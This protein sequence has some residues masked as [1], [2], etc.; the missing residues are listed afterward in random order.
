MCG[1]S[2]HYSYHQFHHYP[3]LQLQCCLGFGYHDHSDIFSRNYTYMDMRLNTTTILSTFSFLCWNN[4]YLTNCT[5]TIG[6][7]NVSNT[8]KQV[9]HCK[10][11]SHQQLCQCAKLELHCISSVK[12]YIGK[13]QHIQHIHVQAKVVLLTCDSELSGGSRWGTVVGSSKSDDTTLSPSHHQCVGIASIESLSPVLSLSIFAVV[14]L[15][16]IAAPPI[17][18]WT[19]PG[20]PP[21]VRA[22]RV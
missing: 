14:V 2:E 12:E 13:K 8:A 5:Y 20:G 21:V 6:Q 3:H 9:E 18:H 11:I 1:Y 22:V 19:L 15:S 17:V 4:L 10:T 7:K 16:G